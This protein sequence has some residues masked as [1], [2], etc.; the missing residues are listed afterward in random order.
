[1]VIVF[2]YATTSKKGHHNDGANNLVC[3]VANILRDNGYE[4]HMRNGNLVSEG[5]DDDEA[6]DARGNHGTKDDDWW[7][8]WR[9][10]ADGNCVVKFID[11]KYRRS[12]WCQKESN[13]CNGGT[14]AQQMSIEYEGHPAM[15]I[16]RHIVEH[17]KD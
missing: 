10:F 4:V 9:A 8:E 12:K 6:F 2:S 15:D 1:M 5:F 14:V 13:F 16:A 17:L 3:R 11:A 7:E